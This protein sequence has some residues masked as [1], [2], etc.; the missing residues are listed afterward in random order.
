MRSAISGRRIICSKQA[1]ASVQNCLA[2]PRRIC[3]YDG[4]AARHHVEQRAADTLF[5]TAEDEQVEHLYEFGNVV[6]EA[7]E[8]DMVFDA[9]FPCE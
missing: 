7:R 1:G 6:P 3:R 2:H 9:D 4:A 5:G 8:C